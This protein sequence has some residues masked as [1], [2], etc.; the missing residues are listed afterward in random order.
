MGEVNR[1]EL[2][3]NSLRKQLMEID[4][5]PVIEAPKTDREVELERIEEEELKR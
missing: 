3:V 2:R 1:S 5:K 4:D